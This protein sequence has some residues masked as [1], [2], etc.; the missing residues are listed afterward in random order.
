MSALILLVVV[1]MWAALGFLL[2]KRLVRPRVRSPVAL[3]V[4]TAGLI[5]LWFVGPVADEILG[6]RE[7]KRLCDETPEM[8]F[9]GPIAIGSGWFFDER[10]QRKLWA[11]REIEEGNSPFPKSDITV[12]H[13]E[14]R[15]F[16][17]AWQ[18]EFKS[19]QETHLIQILPIPVLEERLTYLHESTRQMVLV[20][21]WRTSPGGWI[22][23]LTGWGSHAPYQC[24]N[25][26][27]WPQEWNWIKY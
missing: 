2:W 13:A 23:R 26:R 7:F 27:N 16:Q 25:R 15:R 14:G 20:S 22:K 9:Y 24:P 19:S 11:Q 6:A 3:H 18:L 5:L 1:A 10:G 8:K 12:A 17:E 4:A 21:Y